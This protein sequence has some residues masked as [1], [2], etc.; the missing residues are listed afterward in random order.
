MT[1]LERDQTLA[2]NLT[3]ALLT[4]ELE[5][6]DE[7]PKRHHPVIATGVVGA[8]AAGGT[9]AAGLTPPGRPIVEGEDLTGKRIIRP[10]NQ[11][12][13]LQHEGI[14]IGN[15]LVAHVSARQAGEGYVA[16]STLEHFAKG[17]GIRVIDEHPNIEAAKR[18]VGKIGNKV[19]YDFIKNNCQT[20]TENL[21]TGKHPILPRQLRRGVYG[22]LAAGAVGA[23]VYYAGSKALSKRKRGD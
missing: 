8:S 6:K 1:S 5:E 21:V 23:G 9:L 20:F 11:Y 15:G 18:A 14:G 16:T 12:P 3:A 4:I 2:V 7:R 10:H 17:K 13:H 22:G 19:D